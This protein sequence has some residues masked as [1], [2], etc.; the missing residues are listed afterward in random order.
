MVMVIVASF[1]SFGLSESHSAIDAL[2]RGFIDCADVTWVG[3]AG[4]IPE[5]ADEAA[6]LIGM[7][8]GCY[9]EG[10]TFSECS[11]VV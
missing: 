7:L 9:S 10:S 8:S 3:S 1:S 6:A 2:Y 4:V 11:S 5:L